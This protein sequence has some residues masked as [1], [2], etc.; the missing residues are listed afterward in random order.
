MIK[1]VLFASAI[2]AMCML[3]ACGNKDKQEN[4][5]A[6]EVVGE[7]MVETVDSV[8]DTTINAAAEVVQVD[9]TNVNANAQ[10][11]ATEAAKGAK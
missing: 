1:K 6:E 8:G 5:P 10:G 4:Q 11:N 9:S 7:E 3:T 2:C